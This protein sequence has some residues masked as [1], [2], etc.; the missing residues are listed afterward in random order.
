MPRI[1][2]IIGLIVLL[3]LA[4]LGVGAAVPL[5]SGTARSGPQ[6]DGATYAARGAHAVGTRDLIIDG[7][8]PLEAAMWYPARQGE[9]GDA[10]ITYPYQIKMGAPLGKVTIATFRGEATRDA[11]YDLAAGPYPLVVLSPGLSM[12]ASSYAWLAEHLASYGMVVIA[13]EHEEHFDGE[14]NMLWQSAITRP[15]DSLHTLAYVDEQARTGGALEGLI[16]TGK[17]AVIGHSYGGYTSLVSGGAQIDTA[18]FRERCQTAEAG[19]PGVWLCENILPHLA[20]MA[21]LAGLDGVPDGLWPSWSGADV[22]AVVSLAGDAYAFGEDGLAKISVP[23]LAIGG[24]A[25]EDT[26]FMWGTHPTY[27]YISSGAKAR[28]ALEGAEHM[29]FSA[30]CEATPLLM[31]VMSAEFCSDTGWDRY[32]AHDLTAHLATAFLLAE[33]KGDAEAAS[34]LAPEA[35]DFAGVTYNAQGY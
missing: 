10:R 12:G 5:G 13:P 30:P 15:Q 6:P 7:E 31:R 35:V 11:E 8:A 18:G 27:E 21:E 20:D 4:V 14:L 32:R 2:M 22:D 25:D 28:A 29:I 26:P 23:V 24:T 34:A 17:T 1:A 33:L 9:R 3:V 19:D 16:D